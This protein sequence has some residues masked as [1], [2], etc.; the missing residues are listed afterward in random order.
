[1]SMSPTAKSRPRCPIGLALAA[2]CLLLAC[3]ASAAGKGATVSIKGGK[4]AP[5]TVTIKA[6][7]TVVW[8]NGDDRD[9]TVRGADGSFDSDNIEKGGRY[10]FTFKRAGRY[11][12]SCGLHPRLG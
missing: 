6:G 10:S 2:L 3:G 4:F 9:H 1:M 12:Y 7:E 5:A 8:V 11:P